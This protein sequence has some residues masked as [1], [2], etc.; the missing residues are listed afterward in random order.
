MK[1][2]K[3]IFENKTAKNNF[4]LILVFL[5]LSLIS[6]S[7]FLSV[8]NYDHLDGALRTAYAKDLQT[9]TLSCLYGNTRKSLR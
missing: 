9:V 3:R 8:K 7:F 5:T 6:S 2:A 4:I 1:L